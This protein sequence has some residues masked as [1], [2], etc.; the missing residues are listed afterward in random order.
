MA[1]V[2]IKIVESVMRIFELIV[3]WVLYLDGLVM[4]GIVFVLLVAVYYRLVYTGKVVKGSLERELS[5]KLL[6]LASF[7]LLVDFLVKC[8]TLIRQEEVV[9]RGLYFF[10]NH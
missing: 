6:S 5:L 1:C 10:F 9:V 3:D 4:A 8:L 7:F 2:V